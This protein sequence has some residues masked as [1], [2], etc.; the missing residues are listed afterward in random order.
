MLSLPMKRSAILTGVAAKPAA[1]LLQD[2]I[3]PI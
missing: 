2:S 3:R 1:A